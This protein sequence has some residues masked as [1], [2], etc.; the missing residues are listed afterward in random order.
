MEDSR[1]NKKKKLSVTKL[2]QNVELS[3]MSQEGGSESKNWRKIKDFE[4]R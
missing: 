2:F 4:E 1:S 3:S